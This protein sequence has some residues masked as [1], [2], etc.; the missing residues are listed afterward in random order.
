MPIIFDDVDVADVRFNDVELDKVY[1]DNVLVWERVLK[2]YTSEVNNNG[3]AINLD[4]YIQS[5]RP[6]YK[7]DVIVYVNTHI[8]SST[9]PY[10]FDVGSNRYTKVFIVNNGGTI[11]GYGGNGGNPGARGYYTHLAHAPTPPVGPAEDGVG[12]SGVSFGG[13]RG[14]NGGNAIQG[15][16]VAVIINPDL[17]WIRGGGGGGGAG[18]SLG[19]L[20]DGGDGSN[21]NPGGE[22]GGGAGRVPG[23]TGW[24][25]NNAAGDG[26]GGTNEK[27]GR[28]GSGNGCPVQPDASG[29]GGYSSGH[30]E[31]RWACGS[32]GNGGD[33][34]CGGGAGGGSAASLWTN[35]NSIHHYE[36]GSGSFGTITSHGIG[37]ASN[38]NYV[39]MDNRRGKMGIGGGGGHAGQPITNARLEYGDVNRIIGKG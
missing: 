14:L 9:A 13:T 18:G 12:V 23:K 38:A 35:W 10:A 33:L 3:A 21:I 31:N 27:G 39:G 2:I 25:W 4:N 19:R 28:G 36:G 29:L 20:L 5:V 8:G 11:T 15:R 37:G 6:G 16:G 17:S 22:G 32:G 34:N 30:G 24:R 7:G 26:E 1:F